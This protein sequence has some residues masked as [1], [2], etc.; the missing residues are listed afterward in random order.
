M[1]GWLRPDGPL[2]QR[3]SDRA[4]LRAPMSAA[5]VL[6]AHLV[7]GCA[8]TEPTP[9]I[10]TP[11]ATLSPQAVTASAAPTP[12]APTPVVEGAGIDA[13]PESATSPIPS[14]P[15]QLL[16]RGIEYL[17]Q[18]AS[19]SLT[20]HEVRAYRVIEPSGTTRVIYGEFD[21]QYDVIRRPAFKI[22]ALHEYRYAPRAAFTAVEAYTYQR[23]GG[24]YSRLVEASG[25]GA[26]GETRLEETEPLAGDLYQTLI[27]YSDRAEFVEERDGEAIYVLDHPEWYR[28]RGAAGF[29]NLGFLYG[30]EDGALLV[31]EYVAERYPNVRGVRFTMH[32]AI[33][34]QNIS[35]VMVDDADFMASVWAEVDRALIGEGAEPSGLTRYQVLDANGAE[36]H[37]FQYDSVPDFPIPQ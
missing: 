28:L 31:E 16:E 11:K 17:Q 14:D 30:Q 3:C 2:A 15:T 34:E 37:F 20:V 12:A 1:D 13:A 9:L 22:R 6:A 35:T 8:T 27:T 4:L 26:E 29:A 23:N 21:A 33:D 18:A 36:Y 32:V 5:L 24:Y 7:T 25:V 19:F 10:T